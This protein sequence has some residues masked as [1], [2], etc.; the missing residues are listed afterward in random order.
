MLTTVL[1]CSRL[2]AL[3]HVDHL[4]HCWYGGKSD[5]DDSEVFDHLQALFCLTFGAVG[6]MAVVHVLSHGDHISVILKFVKEKILDK[7]A[8]PKKSP[9]KSYASDLITMTV[10]Y[11]DHVPFLQKYSKEI[12]DMAAKDPSQELNDLITWLKPVE[13]P[14]LFSYDDISGLVNILKKDIDE[15][16]ILP[17]DLITAVRVLKYLGIPLRDHELSIP[18]PDSFEYV[19]LKYKCVIIQLYSLD[20]LAHLS[21]II[22]KLCENYEQPALHSARLVGRQGLTL[23]S[24]LRPAVQLIRK[25][26]THVIKC[27]NTEFK[28]LTMIP[29]LLQTYSLMQAIPLSAHCHIEAQ[30]VRILETGYNYVKHTN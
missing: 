30:K 18:T 12:L 6:K 13:N 11:S 25:V 15:A 26:L 5:P 29:V 28:D 27:R 4:M 19:E 21:A 8:K 22:Q 2:Q 16:T 14:S 7:D 24:F 23:T 9:G 10:K 1:L 20:G 3:S 17:G